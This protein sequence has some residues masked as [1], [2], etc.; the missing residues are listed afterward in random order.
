MTK[1][2]IDQIKR[3]L[4]LLRRVVPDDGEPLAVDSPRRCPVAMF[5]R[6]FLARDPASDVTSAELWTFFAE[7]AAAGELEPLSRSG[8]LRR[9]PGAM[10]A[11]FDVCKSHD[12]ERGDHHLRGF[13][14]VGFRQQA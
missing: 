5:T 7:V 1:T 9:L 2:E 8:F 4:D 3:A 12:V 6:R 13:K 14:G 11:T 10:A